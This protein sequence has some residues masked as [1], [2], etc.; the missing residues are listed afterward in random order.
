MSNSVVQ[1]TNV[2]PVYMYCISY[3]FLEGFI[4]VNFANCILSSTN[5]ITNL[6]TRSNRGDSI[7]LQAYGQLLSFAKISPRENI[8]LVLQCSVS[9]QWEQNWALVTAYIMLL[10]SPL[11]LHVNSI[12]L[13]I[14]G[15]KMKDAATRNR[16]LPEVLLRKYLTFIVQSDIWHVLHWWNIHTFICKPSQMVPCYKAI[17]CL[18]HRR[19]YS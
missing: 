10:V 7:A 2:H 17:P 8:S 4:F 1:H 13:C 3:Y 12:P 16:L 14:L 5:I 11:N 6:S 9:L 18:P 15:Q 19:K